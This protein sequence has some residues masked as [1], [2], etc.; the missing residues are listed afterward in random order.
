MTKCVKCKHWLTYRQL[1][2]II[3]PIRHEG[4]AIVGCTSCLTPHHVEM[5]IKIPFRLRA[6]AAVLPVSLFVALQGYVP[7]LKGWFPL[8]LI[9][10]L[11]LV[12]LPLLVALSVSMREASQ[13]EALRP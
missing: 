1:W 6:L 10:L 11:Y 5:P 3:L 4:S 13:N 8:L 9:V 2:G 7:S 12:A